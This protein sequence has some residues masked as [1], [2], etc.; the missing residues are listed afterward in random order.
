MLRLLKNPTPFQMILGGFAAMILIGTL[1]LML[2]V[3]TASGEWQGFLDALFTATSAVTTTGL[4][5]VSTGP[6]FS[7]FGEA[8]ILVLFQIGGLGYMIIITLVVL[9]IGG[10][11]SISGRSLLRKSLGRPT[12]VEMLGFTKVI[13]LITIAFEIVGIATLWLIWRSDFGSVEALWPAVF[14][15]VSAFCTAGFGLFPESLSGFRESISLNLIIAVLTLPGALGFF[16]L[17][18]LLRVGRSRLGGAQPTSITVHTRIVLWTTLAIAVAGSLLIFLSRGP[19]ASGGL[20]QSIRDA[21]FQSLS[22]ATTTGFNTVDIGALD[23]GAIWT[24]IFQM[25]V[26]ASPGGTGGGIK[27]VGF[28]LLLVFLR[29]HLAGR[30]DVLIHHRKVPRETLMKVFAMTILAISW[31]FLALG[32]MLVTDAEKNPVALIFELVSALGTVGL[33]MGV[34]PELSPVAKVLV[35]FSMFAGRVGPLAIGY[36]LMASRR[37]PRYS[38]PEAE[39]VIT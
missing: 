37:A 13:V 22:A 24:L 34:T 20:F 19:S 35:I 10:R 39:I 9:G 32:V 31:L 27:T 26:G 30:S 1:L 8:V 16:V 17:Y 18:D 36:S 12:S 2:P 4:V 28:V 29:A 7:A 14:H 15:S 11:L 23:I 38:Y 5:V 25:F 3:A 6:F 33:T 21:L